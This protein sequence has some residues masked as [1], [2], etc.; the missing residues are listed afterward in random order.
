VKEETLTSYIYIEDGYQASPRP[1]GP[2]LLEAGL[3]MCP[4]PKINLWR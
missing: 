2:R 3:I 1:V 4:P